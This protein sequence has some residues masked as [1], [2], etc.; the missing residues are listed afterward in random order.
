MTVLL[1]QIQLSSCLVARLIWAQAAD[2]NVLPSVLLI[3]AAFCFCVSRGSGIIS[4]ACIISVNSCHLESVLMK[5]GNA[6]GFISSGV[7][8]VFGRL[9][10]P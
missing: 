4:A 1:V 3:T 7:I 9:F 2:W 6:A 10:I 5:L 8:Q